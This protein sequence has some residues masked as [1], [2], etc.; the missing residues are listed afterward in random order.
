MPK[1]PIANTHTVPI[2]TPA[3]AAAE[4]RPTII[5]ST[6]FIAINPT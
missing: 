3:R 2:A 6:T 1:V 5:T 4:T